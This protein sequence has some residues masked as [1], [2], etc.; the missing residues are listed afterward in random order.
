VIDFRYHLVSIVA[1]FLA[2]ALGIVLGS[3]ELRGAAFSA[4]DKTTN[5][6]KAD[7]ANVQAQRDALQAQAEGGQAFAQAVEPK[8]LADLLTGK[9]LVII[10]EPGAQ[11]SVISGI[12]QAAKDAN[13]TI[14]GQVSLGTASNDTSD[15]MVSK[16]DA[17][18]QTLTSKGVT[19]SGAALNGTPQ[20][21][22]AQLLASAIVTTDS[23]S[24]TSQPSASATDILSSYAASGFLS[25]SGNPGV[26]AQLA[27]IVTPASSPSDGS[28]D[29][30]NQELITQAGALASGSSAT[31]VVGSEAGS[32]SG[33]AIAALR[34]SGTASK[35]S[36]VDNA[37]STIGQ[38]STIEA[39]ASQLAGG[40]A[41][42]YGLSQD[43]AS[44]VAPTPVAAATP[45]ATATATKKSSKRK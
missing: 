42:S 36:S 3:T 20:Q 31:V 2:L 29:P 19:V 7:L 13:A 11:D 23:T 12:T 22:A 45:T 30:A 9:R 33:S 8:L 41:S 27:V 44:A 4:L 21:Q 28:S 35:V 18:T 40:K 43:G 5:S 14:T 16:L 26:R 32:G 39:L 25:T 17:T 6:V 1:V 15:S 37:D 10:T 24:T 38:I 34:A